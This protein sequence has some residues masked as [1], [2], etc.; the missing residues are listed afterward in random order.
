MTKNAITLSLLSSL[1]LAA[2]AENKDKP[3]FIVIFCDDLGY[4]DLACFGHPTIKT[5]NLDK[6][7]INGQKWSSF[8]VSASVSSPSR[9]GLMTGKLG[10]RT[11]MYGNHKRVLFPDSPKGLPQTEQSIATKLKTADYTTAC[12]GKWHIGHRVEDMPMSHGFDYFYGIP[13]SNDMSKKEQALLGNKNYPYTLPFYN[14]KEIIE[15]DID[16]SQLT[17]RLTKYA[18]SF[19]KEHKKEPFFLYL[20]HSMPHVPVYASE[21]FKGKSKAGIYGDAVEELDWSV[22]EIIKS[23]EQNG[24]DDN[25]IVVFSSD[26]GPWLS[27]RQNGGSAGLLRDGKGSTYEGGFRV[28]TIIWGADIVPNHITQMGSTLDLLPTFCEYAGVDVDTKELDGVSLKQVFDG[29][30]VEPREEFFFYRG[31]E[32]YA[33][34]KGKYKMH[35]YVQAAYGQPKKTVLETPVLYDLD[36]DASEKYDIAE[37][38]LEVVRELTALIEQREQ[39]YPA[40]PAIFDMF[41]LSDVIN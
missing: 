8:Y 9:S 34:R 37:G 30:D 24:L 35:R 25:T 14:Q 23:L 17:K 36:V 15:Y 10:A 21:E 28:P 22:G 12:V 2:Y 11:G 20:A 38:N 3:N 6:M 7:S 41:D 31:G 26:N 13:Y 1:T 18:T 29:E 27:Y 32:I 5:P 40:A 16:Q 33:V 4:G 39:D 19:I